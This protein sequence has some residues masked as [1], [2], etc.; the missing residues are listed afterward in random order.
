MKF[1]NSALAY[2]AAIDGMGV[3]M[4]QKEL[5]RD[6]LAVGRLQPAHPLAARLDDVY[7]LAS[8]ADA[9]KRPDIAAFRGWLLSKRTVVA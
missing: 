7:Y 6:D 5:V 8:A 3:A 4:A 1:G 9:H 2:Q